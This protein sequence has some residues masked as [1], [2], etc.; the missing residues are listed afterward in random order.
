MSA[1]RV[2]W[3]ALSLMFV[4]ACAE[5]GLAPSFAV[6]GVGRLLVLVNPSANE[7]G[8]ARTGTEI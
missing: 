3:P 5:E 8:T 4:V 6:G 2:L 1:R 7:N